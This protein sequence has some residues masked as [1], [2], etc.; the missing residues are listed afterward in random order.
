MTPD[1]WSEI[2]RLLDRVCQ[3]EYLRREVESLLRFQS[4]G[5]ELFEEP[6]CYYQPGISE[7]RSLYCLSDQARCA[8]SNRSRCACL[9]CDD[10]HSI[11]PESDGPPTQASLI[12]I[13]RKIMIGQIKAAVY[14]LIATPFCAAGQTQ[15]PPTI[16]Q[17][18][19]ENWVQ[20]VEDASDVSKFATNPNPTTASFPSNFG[21][22]VAIAD[23]VAVNG[24]PV[25]GTMARAQQ[26]LLLNT[27][28]A[29]GRAIADT[30]RIAFAMDTFEIMSTDGNAI[31]TIMISGIAPGALAPPRPLLY[32]RETLRSSAVP[33]RFSSSEVRTASR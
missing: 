14:L 9:R 1:R 12:D 19:I 7:R 23:I 17:I 6:Q 5:D 3:D 10:R 4:K 28:Q 20:Y 24:Q 11:D 25:K 29:P 27:A 13:K 8:S 18:D 22:A 30:V 26:Y 15:N 31:G 32:R 16:L 33:E 21:R 2:D